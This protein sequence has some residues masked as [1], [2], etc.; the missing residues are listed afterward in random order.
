MSDY[1]Y[2]QWFYFSNNVGTIMVLSKSIT[3]FALINIHVYT[4]ILLNTRL[5]CTLR[6]CASEIVTSYQ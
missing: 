3:I 2:V 6:E 4:H 5:F 1:E